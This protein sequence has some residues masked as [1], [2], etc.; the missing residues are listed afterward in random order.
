MY[1]LVPEGCE[2][3]R[4]IRKPHSQHNI[5]QLFNY[6][7]VENQEIRHAGM[8]PCGYNRENAQTVNR[9]GFALDEKVLHLVT[10]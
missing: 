7:D 8:Q 9:I 2:R 4:L 1:L 3:L 6:Q 5:I 10:G